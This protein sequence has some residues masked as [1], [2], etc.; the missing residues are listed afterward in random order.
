MLEACSLEEF[1]LFHPPIL[2]L[3]ED[4]EAGVGE[5]QS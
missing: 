5:F 3:E 1:E 4:L 2:K